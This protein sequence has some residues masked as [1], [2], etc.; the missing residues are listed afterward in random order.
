MDFSKFTQNTQATMANCRELLR[1]LDHAI[2]EPEHIF[3]SACLL[4]ETTLLDKVLQQLRVDASKIR[5][6]LK[7]YLKSQPKASPSTVAR[8][9]DQLAISP[10][11]HDLLNHAGKIAQKM[12]DD[13]VS[14]EH[15]LLAALDDKGEIKKVLSSKG[16]NKD[17]VTKAIQEV[18]KG[19]KISSDNPEGSMDALQKYG[20]DI[21]EIARE[22]KLDP[23]IGRDEEIRRVVQVLSRRRKN[24]PVLVGAPGVGKTAIAEG[25]ALRIVKGDV[26]EGLKN[27]KV[28]ELDM[29]AL[30]AGAKFRGEFEERLKAVLKEVQSSNGEIILFIDELHTVVGAGATEG[31]MDA[32]NLLKPALA[33]GELHCI[34]ATTIDEYR[35]HI[36]KD[37]ALERRFQVVSVDEPS[38]DET[39]SI[40]RGLKE[41][42]EVHHG[43]RIKDNAI[44]AAAKLSHRYIADRFLPDKAIDLID[45]AAAKVRMEIDSSPQEL[46]QLDRKIMQLGI[47]KEALKKEIDAG[48]GASELDNKERLDK[49][50]KELETLNSRASELRKQWQEEKASI[51][52][53]RKVKEQ[54]ED[55]KVQ[56]ELAERKAD[57]QR[58]AEL[59]YGVLPEL[60]KKLKVADDKPSTKDQ[61][62]NNTSLLKEEIDEEDIAAIV[63]RWTGIPVNKL[64]STEA[65]KLLKLEDKLHER[66]IGQDQAITAVANA[67]RRSRAGLANPNRPIGSF[68]FLGPTGVGKTE[69]AK[70]LAEALFDN[71]NALVRIDM[72]EYQEQHT[73]ARLIGAPP[74]YVG[75][76][77]GG[78][79]SEAVRR[80]PYS[81]VLFDEFEKAHPDIFNVLLQILD[82]GHLTDGKGRKVDFKNT[83]I[84]MTSNFGSEYILEHQLGSGLADI[85][86][87]SSPEHRQADQMNKSGFNDVDSKQAESK[88]DHLPD[89]DKVSHH[90]DHEAH[91]ANRQ[92]ELA[93]GMQDLLK[94]YFRPEFLN[95]ID[96]IITFSGLQVGQMKSIVK[97]Q[98]HGLEERLQERKVDLEITDYAL[99]QLGIIGFDPTYGARPLKRVIQQKIEN[100]LAN[101][102]LAG[103]LK[104][105]SK[106]T[107]DF[108]DEFKFKIE[109]KEKIK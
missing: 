102:I 27:K 36:E 105:H 42:Y 19:Q 53:V 17:N 80:K 38:T 99:E 89:E 109:A 65:E 81:I 60:E 22:G 88:L 7:E 71:E 47:E 30:I 48:S 32:S 95:R 5:D 70:A 97:V 35:K 82:D 85:S 84:I 107:I 46:D 16:L 3:V 76:E 63:S 23:V 98:I 77:E 78:Q 61:S 104:D 92:A 55:T 43:V 103:K 41:K 72:S 34:G 14:L 40:L 79:L 67:V 69:L 10:R 62:K 75:Y 21:T 68:M 56:I 101:L 20:K 8:S 4:D 54:I 9:Q 33:R 12:H 51:V 58:A 2:I 39:I 1:Q 52:D 91:S 50:E 83:I 44:V 24:N 108:D 87:E 57:L 73:A 96:E 31:S 106:V 37:A 11:S 59:K 86:E 29:G 25:L 93:E 13:Y 100:E 94:S 64:L 49:I 6:E 74:G 28:V 15:L 45:E 90:H 66:V 18:R 26:P